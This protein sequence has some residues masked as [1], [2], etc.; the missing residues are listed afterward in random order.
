[1]LIIG[2]IV[3]AIYFIKRKKPDAPV[4]IAPI[5]TRPAHEI[6]LEELEKSKKKNYGNKVTSNFI[7]HDYLIDREAIFR[8]AGDLMLWKKPPMKLCTVPFHNN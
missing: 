5:P 1:M 2:I 3:L 4:S 8:N 6:A 7:T